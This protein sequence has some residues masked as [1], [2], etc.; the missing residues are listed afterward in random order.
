MSYK[1][2][3]ANTR[4]YVPNFTVNEWIMFR[5]RLAD[6]I[7]KQMLSERDQ[8]I[9]TEIII[10]NKS[11]AQLAYLAQNDE[12]YGWLQSNQRRPMSVR[13]IQ[14]ILIKKF[15]EFHIQSTHKKTDK[16]SKIRREQNVIRKTMITPDSV[17]SKCGSKENLEIHHMLPVAI[18]GD[19][20]DRNL[21]ILCHDCHR[22]TT[23][24][25]KTKLKNIKKNETELSE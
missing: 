1:N 7:E 8:K 4:K 6:L 5:E 22:Q 17:C 23:N 24:Y 14:N 18:G 3:D 12:E 2:G 20:D 25:F 10:N 16:I 11:T 21:I 9:L 13:Q 15:P 19:N